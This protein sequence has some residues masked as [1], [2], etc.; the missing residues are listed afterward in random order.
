M[1]R[2]PQARSVA[3]NA[4]GR[5]S[6]RRSLRHHSVQQSAKWITAL[7]PCNNV[8][9]PWCNVC[10]FLP[11]FKS[12]RCIVCQERPRLPPVHSSN[13]QRCFRRPLHCPHTATRRTLSMIQH[14]GLLILLRQV[15]RQGGG[16]AKKLTRRW[17]SACTVACTFCG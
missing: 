3:V 12:L 16:G 1:G 10:S 5:T 9:R 13:Y 17:K 11:M 8:R 14:P 2:G 15:A 7:L 4:C 6:S